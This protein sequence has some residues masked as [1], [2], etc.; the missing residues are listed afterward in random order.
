MRNTQTSILVN[1]TEMNKQ[2]LGSKITKMFLISSYLLLFAFFFLKDSTNGFGF[3]TDRANIPIAIA[4]ANI[5]IC[6]IMISYS[7]IGT[8]V[9]TLLS[10]FW[11]FQFIFFGIVNYS[12]LVD[13]F[14]FYLGG[15]AEPLDLERATYLSFFCNFTA[16]I[17]QIILANQK[18]SR[19]NNQF[20]FNRDLTIFRHRLKILSIAY[21]L[22][23]IPVVNFI[24]GSRF[25]FNSGSIYEG[26]LTSTV[27]IFS[28][29]LSFVIVIPTIITT[30]LLFIR[31]YLNHK[32]NYV[33]LISFAIWS[34]ILS[35]P[36]AHPRSVVL[37]ILIPIFFVVTTKF[38]KLTII[39]VLSIPIVVLYFSNVINRYN[40]AI[41]LVSQNYAT[42][43]HGDYDAFMQLALGIKQVTNGEFPILNQALGSLLF[44]FPR[45]IWQSKPLDTGVALA[46]MNGLQFQNLSAPWILE[47]FVNLRVFGVFFVSIFIIYILSKF[48]NSFNK[49]IFNYLIAAILSGS[50]FILLRGSLLQATGRIAFSVLLIYYLCSN[51]RR[52][53]T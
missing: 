21:L 24:G 8:Q 49:N 27:P 35:Y 34:L 30:S 42:S 2:Q 11:T 20:P 28:I 5:I 37:F 10:L 6:S 45:S 15:L 47:A 9:Q 41:K 53:K 29:A 12:Y 33:W 19:I 44:Y 26:F 16:A 1:L 52:K 38:R 40:G 3:I 32:V 43:R 46:Q 7:L 50:I 51:F 18:K 14:P 31:F 17:T 48:D 25:L 36:P 13:S 39:I 22:T 23:F 4:I